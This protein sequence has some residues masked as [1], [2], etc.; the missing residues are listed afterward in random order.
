[1]NFGF[2]LD[3]S[4]KDLWYIDLLDTHLDFLDV[5]IPSK[6]FVCLQNV[7]KTCI[8]DVCKICLKDVFKTIFFCLGDVLEEERL[9]RWRRVK[10]VFKTCLMANKCLKGIDLETTFA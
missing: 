7:F 4:D 5:D 8:Q 10:D 1:M 2:S 9:L 6:H 3:L